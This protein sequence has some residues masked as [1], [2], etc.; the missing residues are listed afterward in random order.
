[1][2]L[3][4]YRDLHETLRMRY[5]I[6]GADMLMS[7]WLVANTHYADES[8][9]FDGYQF[10]IAIA[11]DMHPNLAVKKCSQVG[12]ALPL[13]T[14][15]PTPSGWTTMG[16][17]QPGD[18]IFDEQGQPTTVTFK[19]EVHTDHICYEITF[20][21]GTTQ[22]ADAEHRWQ[23][24]TTRGPFNSEGVFSGRGRP[25]KSEGYAHSGVVDTQFLF[26]NHTKTR[27]YIPLTQPLDLPPASLPMDPYVYGTR[28]K[29]GNRIPIAYQRGSV[30]QRLEL[31]RGLMDTGGGSITTTGGWASFH[32]TEAGLVQDVQDLLHGLGYKTYTRTRTSDGPVF[33]GN[34]VSFV[35]DQTPV[36]K[37]NRQAR[38]RFTKSRTITSV[39]LVATVPTQ[40]LTVDAPSHLFLAGRS[41]VP[42]HNTE[43]QIRKFFAWLK[44]HPGKTGIFTLPSEKLFKRISKMRIKPWLAKEAVFNSSYDDGVKPTRSMDMYQIDSSFAVISGL[45]EDD[46]TSTSADILFHDELDL[47]DMSMID[48]AQSRLQNSDDKITQA[49]STPKYPGYGIDSRFQL[50]DQN[51]YFHR[52]PSCNHLQVP[53]FDLKFLNLSSKT[54]YFGPENIL[55][56][57][58]DQINRIQFQDLRV[59]CERCHV[60]IDLRDH[61]TRFYV[62]KY[63]GRSLIRGYNVGPFSTHRIP[64]DYIFSR[65]IKARSANAI[66]GFYNT[67]LGRPYVDGNAQLSETEIRAVMGDAVTHEVGADIPCFIG[68]DVGEVCHIV[69]GPLFGQSGGVVTFRTCLINKLYDVIEELKEKYNIVG[70]TIDRHPQSHVANA[71]RDKFPGIMPCEY[72]GSAPIRMVVSQETGDVTHCQVDRT[73]AIDRVVKSIRDGTLRLEGYGAQ[74]EVLITHLRNMVREE[75][76]E[77]PA[78]WVK[79]SEDDHFFHAL[80]FFLVAPRMLEMLFEHTNSSMLSSAGVFSMDDLIFSPTEGTGRNPDFMKPEPAAL[81]TMARMKQRGP[82]LWRA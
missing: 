81:S 42:T 4:L 23:V 54:G 76:P 22:V 13:D 24:Q 34:E 50:S 53:E 77:T 15:L 21:D 75:E 69:V 32:N 16:E 48:L 70:G 65:L 2:S 37:R 33:G 18:Q 29:S 38:P 51:E 14:P 39:H 67:V 12:L 52:C 36:F 74:A 62:T 1:M 68:I 31:L 41:M 79:L 66:G 63:P 78:K 58:D 55:E 49:F 47:S 6:D 9:S 8:F 28:L 80:V 72:R 44:R 60:P 64:P 73:D 30:E 35:P 26:E 19:S 61:S 43:T 20:D 7:D 10:Q 82:S 57:T 27:F 46:A 71:V 56:A 5:P 11:N 40:C 45:T 3:S 25:N 59:Q 17:V